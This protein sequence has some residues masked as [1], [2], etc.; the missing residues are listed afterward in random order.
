MVPASAQPRWTVWV[1]V[2]TAAAHSPYYM[3]TQHGKGE[4]GINEISESVAAAA[5]SVQSVLLAATNC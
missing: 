1:S 5:G 4:V 3:Q 2:V